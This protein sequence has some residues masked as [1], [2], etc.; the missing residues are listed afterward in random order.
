VVAVAQLQVLLPRQELAVEAERLELAQAQQEEE[1]VVRQPLEV[2]VQAEERQQPAR[3]VSFAPL[4][5][6]LPWLPYPLLLF[7]PPQLPRRQARENDRAP[8]PLRL[9][10]SNWSVFFSR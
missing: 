7:V 5:L 1:V 2:A 10:Q 4:W 9:L 8:S 6:Q 3:Q